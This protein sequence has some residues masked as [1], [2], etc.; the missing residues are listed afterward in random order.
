MKLQNT[1]PWP[2]PDN[3]VCQSQVKAGYRQV[4][5]TWR[6][7]EWRYEARWH[8]R[9]PTAQ[10][11]TYPSWRL[12]RVRPGKG[13]GPLAAPRLEETRAGDHWLSV[14][15]VRYAAARYHHGDAL[16]ADIA[17][18]RATHPAARKVFPGK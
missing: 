2:I 12:D 10:L 4:K 13:Y 14:S 16:P 18:L 1:A 8:E 3:A 11:I 5:Y 15:R 7:A 17:I 9:T 6:D